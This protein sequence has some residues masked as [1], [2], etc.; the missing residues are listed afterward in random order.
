LQKG[1]TK[2]EYDFVGNLT[3]VDY[4]AS[5]DLLFSYDALNRATND[6][7]VGG[8]TNRYTYHPGG[9]LASERTLNWANSTVTSGYTSQLRTS[10]ALEQ[11]NLSDWTHTYTYD[12][13]RRLSSVGGSSGTFNYT[14][15]SAS[16]TTASRLIH[17]I[18]LPTTS[19]GPSITNTYDNVGRLLTTH[20]RNGG[21]IF[22][23]HNYV[24]DSAHRRTKQ[25][26]TDNSYVNYSYD[27]SS[28]LRTAEAYTSGGTPI[29]TEQLRYGYDEAQ[30]MVKRTNH[31]TVVTYNVNVRN[32]VTTGDGF[33]Y[34][35]DGN[36]NRT[37][38]TAYGFVEYQYDD[39]NQLVSAR[40]DTSTTSEGN[41]WRTDWTYDAR[42]RIRQKTEYIWLSG[43]WYPNGTIRYVYDGMRVIQQRSSSNVSQ[44][45]YT[46]GPDLSGSW[47][48]AGGIGGLLARTAHSGSWG[49]TYTHAFYHADG[50][51]N[52]TYLLNMN[53]TLG[54]AY[55]YDAYGRTLSSSGTLASANV[56]R[57][58]SKEVM[59]QSGL[60]Y[61][62]YRFYDPLTQRWVNRDPIGESGGINLYQ[63]NRNNPTM[64]ID[65]WG[66]LDL[67]GYDDSCRKWPPSVADYR[68]VGWD[69]N[70][71]MNSPLKPKDLT[72]HAKGVYDTL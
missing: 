11:Q 3:K 44:V 65:P 12:N 37:Y 4:P 8:I 46:R 72:G 22:N 32:Q 45:T 33:S 9:Q 2:Y 53:Q 42:G 63:M 27:P 31:T 70:N 57:F 35:Y 18:T 10:L 26:R 64:R 25:T 52:I 40:T 19:A 61:F 56:Y 34:T 47:E 55:R 23:K 51:G 48:G 60:Y 6:V 24:V 71:L 1:N 16:G 36:G 43:S 68:P 59:T 28:Q 29:T 49:V 5:A 39:E 67:G 50:N 7:R 15:T 30:N 54:A 21:T 38:R 17:R 13:A 69:P 66:L 41:R 62:G 14:Y 58:S 20:M